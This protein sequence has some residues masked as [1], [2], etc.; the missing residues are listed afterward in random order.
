MEENEKIGKA[1]I[2]FLTRT[3]EMKSQLDVIHA[4]TMEKSK[5]LEVIIKKEKEMA[6]F[7]RKIDESYTILKE[8]K[9]ADEIA[10]IMGIF[11]KLR[12]YAL[13]NEPSDDLLND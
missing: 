6:D 3:A 5:L 13:E 9:P 8:N 10:Y 1:T 2:T 12:T 4:L 7:A 11:E